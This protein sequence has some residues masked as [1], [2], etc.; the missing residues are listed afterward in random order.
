MAKPAAAKYDESSIRV[1]KDLEAVRHRPGMYTV[2]TSP[3][4]IVQEAI[5]N[6]SDECLA[7]HASQ[8]TVSMH[9]DGSLSVADDGRGIPVGPHPTE[10]LPVI[11]LI[12][13]RLHSG[14]KFDKTSG[15]AYR[16]S[17]GLHGVG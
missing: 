3:L 7:G 2:T 9:I 14:G 6:A 1:L 11:E 4:H 13:T 16:F 17:G 5:D 15:G 8:V 12:F 10:K